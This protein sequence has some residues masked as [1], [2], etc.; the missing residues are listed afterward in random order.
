MGASESKTVSE[1][2]Q[3]IVDLIDCIEGPPPLILD[4]RNELIDLRGV[5]Q[6]LKLNF[7][8]C[9]AMAEVWK[10]LSE[11][12][13]IPYA[14]GTLERMC[15][16]GLSFMERWT[17]CQSPNECR[18]KDGFETAFHDNNIPQLRA[19]FDYYRQTLRLALNT[20]KL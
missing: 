7:K 17:Y 14:V 12:V 20:C 16:V 10:D 19:H 18:L 11:S 9:T 5:F 1:H 3:D 4:W 13:K 6:V 8:N 15:E 2:I